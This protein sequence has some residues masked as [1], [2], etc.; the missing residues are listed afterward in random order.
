[1]APF[2]LRK[3][4]PADPCIEG[5]EA[6]VKKFL[7][8]PYQIYAWLVFYP[9]AVLITF[10]CASGAVL[11]A[12]LVNPHFASRVFGTGW[13]RI[14]SALTPMRVD[15]EGAAHA[16]PGNSYIVVSNHQSVF[17][18]LVLYGWLDLDLKWVMKAELR[19]MPAIG[20]SCETIGHIYVDRK[21]RVKARQA[22]NDALDRLGDGIG[23]LFFAEGTRSGDGKLLPFKKGAFHTA[24]EQQV[25]LLPVSVVGTRDIMP[26]RSLLPFPGRVRLIIHEAIPTEGM[27]HDDLGELLNRTRDIIAAGLESRS[28]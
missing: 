17:D 11:S 12:W 7:F 18:I 14:L 4:V 16:Q 24:I 23:I 20:I 22:I 2:F 27:T 21:D 15:V 9:L 19:K 26:A 3:I 8:W 13:A 1:M 25:P 5:P 6:G 10:V 28:G